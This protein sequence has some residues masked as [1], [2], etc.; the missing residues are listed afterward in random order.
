MNKYLYL[1]LVAR[2]SNQAG[3]EVV[4]RFNWWL[5]ICSVSIYQ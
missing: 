5:V 4:T 2:P 3:H 1:G